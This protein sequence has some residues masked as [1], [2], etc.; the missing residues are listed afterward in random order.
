MKNANFIAGQLNLGLQNSVTSLSRLPNSRLPSVTN[1]GASQI[2]HANLQDSAQEELLSYSELGAKDIS[3]EGYLLPSH[4]YDTGSSGG[5][6]CS[7]REFPAYLP[8]KHSFPFNLVSPRRRR[9]AV[10]PQYDRSSSLGVGVIVEEAEGEEGTSPTIEATLA[11]NS[12]ETCLWK[13]GDDTWTRQTP[14]SAQAGSERVN[15]FSLPSDLGAVSREATP[16]KRRAS[17]RQARMIDGALFHSKTRRGKVIGDG[18]INAGSLVKDNENDEIQQLD[19]HSA[20]QNTRGSWL[21]SVWARFHGEHRRNSAQPKLRNQ[22]SS[23][24]S[25][26]LV[27]SPPFN[28]SRAFQLS[29][30]SMAE[31]KQT[32]PVSRFGLDGACE[33]HLNK[34]LPLSP[35]DLQRPSKQNNIHRTFFGRS[36]KPVLPTTEVLPPSMF[37]RGP[38]PP[39]DVD[40]SSLVSAT[41]TGPHELSPKEKSWSY[42]LSDSSLNSGPASWVSV[43]ILHEYLT[44]ANQCVFVCNLCQKESIS[45]VQRTFHT[46]YTNS[47]CTT[48]FPEAEHFKRSMAFQNHRRSGA[49]GH[50]K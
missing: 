42:R 30:S 1:P 28:S 22:H 18:N 46:H 24:T 23:L 20:G 49:S 14:P 8:R 43:S 50:Y 33:E 11:Y 27:G 40:L 4:R 19:V 9:V 3:D 15:R 5:G 29:K 16:T 17:H 31:M 39:K 26:G 34:P 10:S 6:A 7:P 13:G 38:S 47:T 36:P 37:Q 35:G 48:C 2:H 32:G 41:M 44:N 45:R 25:C 21:R 12:P